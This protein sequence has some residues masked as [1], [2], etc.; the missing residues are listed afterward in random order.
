MGD[1]KLLFVYATMVAGGL[2][3][4]CAGIFSHALRLAWMY[5]SQTA[6]FTLYCSDS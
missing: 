4:L 1:K 5:E 2:M 3:R 6:P